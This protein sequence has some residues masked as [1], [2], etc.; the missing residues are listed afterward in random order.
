M[1]SATLDSAAVF[2]ERCTKF[3][4]APE[5]LRK[6]IAAGYDTFG[7][8]A[9]AAG[10]NPM[11]LTDTAVDDWLRTIEDPLPSPFQVSVVRRLVYESQNV[12][13]ADLKARVEPSSEVQTRKLPVAERLV[14]QEEQAKRL[15][16]LQFTPHSMPGHACVDEVVNMIESNTLK[17]I[18]LNRWVS[19]S[20]ELALRKSDPAVSLDSEGK[21][22]V[23]GKNPELTCDTSGLYALRQAFHRRA[24]AFD[25]GHLATFGCMDAWTNDIFERT[26]RTPPKGYAPVNI[27]QLLAAD[28]ELFVQAAHRLEGQLQGAASGSRPLDLVMKELCVSPE[29]VQHLLPLV[30]TPEKTEGLPPGKRPHTPGAPSLQEGAALRE[31]KGGGKSKKGKKDKLQIVIPPGCAS[32]DSQNRPNCFQFNLG[33]CALKVSKGRCAKGYH[34]CWRVGCNQPHPFTECTTGHQ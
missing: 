22:K 17:Y 6:M 23:G 4:L 5:L 9:F 10:A 12:S 28:K 31:G 20:Q 13:I 30:A 16:G 29:V 2:R 21:L 27:G 15:S 11:T 24:L 8:V 18:P 32:R 3:G 14:R 19:R 25:L 26:Q 34:Q 7:K 1:A 33:K